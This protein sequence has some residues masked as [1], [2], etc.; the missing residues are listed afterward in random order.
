M[1]SAGLYASLHLIPGS[2]ANIP[3]LSFLQADALPD[4]QPIALKHWRQMRYHVKIILLVVKWH[5]YINK[6]LIQLSAVSNLYSTKSGGC[7]K[8]VLMKQQINIQL[9]SVLWHCWFGGRKSIQPITTKWRGAGV[10]ICLQQGAD[11]LHTVQ[12]MPLPPHHLLLH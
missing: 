7:S 12:L 4:A 2:H 11:D 1:P 6:L 3:P 5:A 10:V 8:L 9:P